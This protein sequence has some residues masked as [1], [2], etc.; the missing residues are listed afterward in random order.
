MNPVQ[1]Y[2][3]KNQL[4]EFK[5]NI[6]LDSPPNSPPLLSTRE[7]PQHQPN[8]ALGEPSIQVGPLKGQDLFSSLQ[9]QRWKIEE[10]EEEE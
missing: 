1:L 10:E 5:K 3:G 7:V 8:C 2:T 6:I 9:V 4:F